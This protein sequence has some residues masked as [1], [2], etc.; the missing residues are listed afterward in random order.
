MPSPSAYA[1]AQR[2]RAAGRCAYREDRAEHRSDAR[3]PA[4]SE[5]KPEDVRGERVAADDLEVESNIAL[6][7]RRLA[8]HTEH[9][10][11]ENDDDGPA[12]YVEFVAIA[13]EKLPDR[14]RAGAEGDEHG[15]EAADEE[16]SDS[17]RREPPSNH[18][19]R[20]HVVCAAT[21]ER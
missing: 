13:R 9:Q 18:R 2:R 20:R 6:Q 5:R 14:R 17:K 3:R 16:R 1:P 21:Y 10:Q 15:G 11:P 7:P 19:R 12:D 4:K 8:Q